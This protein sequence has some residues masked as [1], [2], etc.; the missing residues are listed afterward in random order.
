MTAG[1]GEERGRTIEHTQ[2]N[3]S[4]LAERHL[5]RRLSAARGLRI[6][7]L[8]VRARWTEAL[9]AAKSGGGVVNCGVVS[10]ESTEK[11]GCPVLGLQAHSG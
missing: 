1:V 2:Y 4:I 8:A 11:T 10:G 5:T 6:G 7:E 3:R 9:G